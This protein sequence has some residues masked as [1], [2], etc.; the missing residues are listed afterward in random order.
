[1]GKL[2]PIALGALLVAMAPA[3]ARAQSR[4][5]GAYVLFALEG[6]R[7]KGIAVAGGGNV[8][9]NAGTGL[10]YASSH[11]EIDAPGS[12]VVAATVRAGDQSLCHALYANA[13]VRPM[14]GCGPASPVALPLVPN[15]AAACG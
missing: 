4:D 11:A 15:P 7:T 8:G 2:R 12:Q 9:V 1:M 5:V 3:A 14:A 6:L 13:V 10:I